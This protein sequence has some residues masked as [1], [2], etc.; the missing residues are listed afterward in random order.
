V[1]YPGEGFTLR[2]GVVGKWS[3]GRAHIP[4]RVKSRLQIIYNKLPAGRAM[5]PL[6][7][8]I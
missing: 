7:N 2:T 8:V 5:T 4:V 6:G 1:R 3:G